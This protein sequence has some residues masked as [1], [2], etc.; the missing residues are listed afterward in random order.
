MFGAA[1]DSCATDH[2]EAVRNNVELLGRRKAIMMS[3]C[4]MRRRCS[5]RSDEGDDDFTE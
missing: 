3:V 5:A 4:V 1:Y 2:H